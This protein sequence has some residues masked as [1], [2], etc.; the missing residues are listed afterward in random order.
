MEELLTQMIQ[1]I[2]DKPDEVEVDELKGDKTTVLELKVAKED[3][4][5]AIGKKGKTAHAIRTILNATATKMK[6]RAVLEIVE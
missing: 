3:L 6:Q 2:V 1:A 4:G 5:K